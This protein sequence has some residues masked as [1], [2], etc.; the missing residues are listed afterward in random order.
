[1]SNFREDKQLSMLRFGD[2]LCSKSQE[3][4]RFEIEEFFPQAFFSKILPN[5]RWKKWA[6]YLDKYLL[7]P[8]KIKQKLQSFSKPIDLVHII[9]HSNSFY[10]PQLIKISQAKKIITCHD[11]IAIRTAHGEFPHAP[12]TSR[13]GKRLQRWIHNS[14]EHVDYYACDSLQTKDNL[15]RL[16]PRSKLNSSVLHLG[17]E[18][19]FPTPTEQRKSIENLPFNPCKTLFLLHVGSAAWYKNRKAVYKAFRHASEK[20]PNLNLKLIL[21]GP[22]PQNEEL[23]VG[24]S[25]WFQSHPNSLI[26]LNNLSENSLAELYKYSK[27]LVFP[28]F[29]EGF[30]WPPLEAAVRGCPVITTRTGAISD[31]LGNYAK[32]VEA[33]NQASIDQGVM[34]ALQLPRSTQGAIALPSHEDC[35]RQ[36]FDLYEQVMAN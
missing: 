10:L 20:L 6:A 16:V 34:Q 24:L 22:K 12:N 35:R 3:D 5:N 17:T 32:Y 31:L 23:D 14:L 27:A 30:G 18:T 8:K 9:D 29:I 28:S 19:N 13:T 25:D 2:L 21:V 4:P 7:F 26:C 33:E 1:L 15:N 11:L 36:Y